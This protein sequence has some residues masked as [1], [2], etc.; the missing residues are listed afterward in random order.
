M[1]LRKKVQKQ[2]MDLSQKAMEKLFADEK[3]AA[4]VASAIGAVQRG[5]AKFDETQR[6]VLNQLSF[7]S[8]ADFKE[9]G[10]R[11]SAI[12][13]RVRELERKLKALV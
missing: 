3:R 4:K 6:T 13:Q 2:A 10:K 5:K 9:L 7:A 12:K 11:F 8:K 1:G